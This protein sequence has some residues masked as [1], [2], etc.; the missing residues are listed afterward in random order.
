MKQPLNIFW[1]R[2]D[3]RLDDNVGFYNALKVD[4]PVLPIFIF[5][6]EILNELPEDDARV[7]FIFNTLQSMRNTLQD[8][9][10]SSIAIYYSTP[11]EVF[12]QLVED[13]EIDTVYTNHDYEPYAKTRDTEIETILSENDINFKTFKDQVIFE[14]DEVVK[15]DGDPYVVYTPYMRT[16]KENFKNYDLNIYY[17]NEYLDNLVKNTRLPNVTLSDMGFKTSSQK[18]ADYTVTPTL[19]QE[20][21]D[22]RNFPAKDATS[23]LGPHL[24][25]GTVSVRKMVKKAIA[26]KNEIF[27]QELIWREFFMQI[28]WHYPKTQTN[29]FKSKYDNIKWRNNKEEFEAWKTGNTGYPL[30]DAGMRELNA[31]GF[32]H[33][34]VRMLVGS[35][36]C[37]HL[38]IDWRWGEA[39]F[40]EKLH[41]YEMASNVGN[42]QW[43]AGSGVDAAPYFRI[44]NP[45]T[46]IDK[47]DKEHKYIKKWVPEYQDQKY[48]KPIVDHKEARER[49]LKVYKEAVS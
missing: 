47:F 12:K 9:R 44:F 14:K 34:R 45:T 23:K 30:V 4:K 6:K 25:F 11:K 42:W 29:A 40:A 41:D 21:E 2:R 49:C 36:L 5:D 7:T 15:Q 31:T 10:D 46:Q 39:Y 19:I 20:Y 22:K 38:L 48:T 43:V 37:K 18:I 35:F 27:W 28:L 8:E 33:N 32:M 26:E 24:R 13:Y 1:F 3:L 17:T 16:W